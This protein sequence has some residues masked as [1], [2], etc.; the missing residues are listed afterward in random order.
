MNSELSRES[1]SLFESIKQYDEQGN[2][3]WT[4]RTLA[5]ILEYTDYRNFLKVIDKAK[6]ACSNS[7]QQA[8]DHFVN[9]NDM[10]PIGKGGNRPA[11][12]VKTNPHAPL[13]ACIDDHLLKSFMLFVSK[14]LKIYTELLANPPFPAWEIEL[15]ELWN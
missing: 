5:R 3:Y 6:E 12:T 7:N 13:I 11:I 14:N 4:S 8:S 9:F 1:I 15:S 10:I 2:E